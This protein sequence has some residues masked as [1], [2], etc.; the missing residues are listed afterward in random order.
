MKKKDLEKLNEELTENSRER[1]DFIKFWANYIKTH[2]DEE[3][4]KQQNIL[5]NSIINFKKQLPNPAS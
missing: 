3:W 1:L 4:S 2:S 5:I